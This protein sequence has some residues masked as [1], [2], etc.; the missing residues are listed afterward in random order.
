MRPASAPESADF[1]TIQMNNIR[2]F[3]LKEVEERTKRSEFF[4]DVNIAVKLRICMVRIPA[5]R[6]FSNRRPF[7]PAATVLSNDPLEDGSQGHTHT[8][9]LPP[10]TD[11]V[12]TK[13]FFSTHAL[14]V[15]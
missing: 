12:I 13:G 15:T 9:L 8:F 6:S 5:N 10:H 7:P 11:L 2:L 1:W 3:A 14:I 4:S